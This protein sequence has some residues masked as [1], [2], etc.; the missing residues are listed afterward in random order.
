MKA[1]QVGTQLGASLASKNPQAIMQA[2]VQAGH[3]HLLGHCMGPVP[4][5]AD[6]A[7]CAD[8]GGRRACQRA[9]HIYFNYS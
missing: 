3:G 8:D 5:C 1:L 6:Q 7:G 2:G 4:V 9:A